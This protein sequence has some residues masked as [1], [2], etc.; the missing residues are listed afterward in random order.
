MVGH[1]ASHHRDCLVDLGSVSILRAIPVTLGYCLDVGSPVQRS[2]PVSACP[3][4]CMLLLPQLGLQ[5]PPAFQTSPFIVL[6]LCICLSLLQNEEFPAISSTSLLTDLSSSGS[7]LI[8]HTIGPRAL[9]GHS[10]VMRTS[11]VVREEPKPC[12]AHGGG[13]VCK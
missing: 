11:S 4:S 7:P 10:W 5:L 1:L 3:Y 13:G 8:W 2:F 6:S 9:R 12:R